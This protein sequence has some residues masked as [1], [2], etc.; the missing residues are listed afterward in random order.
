MKRNVFAAPVLALFIMGLAAGCATSKG[1]IQQAGKVVVEIGEAFTN[2]CKDSKA[3]GW[4]A[5]LT[6]DTCTK[7][8]I[9]YDGIWAATKLAVR[10]GDEANFDLLVDIGKFV[11]D[12]V[13]LLREAGV[14]IP[15]TVTAFV[16]EDVGKILTR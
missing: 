9:A 8:S 4:A 6:L 5:P 13:A 1:K 16:R 2:A 3:K 11:L 15:D 12:M 14:D 10:V 7:G